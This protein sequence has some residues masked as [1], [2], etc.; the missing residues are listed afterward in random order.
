MH[1]AM[2][3]PQVVR[4]DNKLYTGGGFTNDELAAKLIVVF[5]IKEQAWS[6]YCMGPTIEFGLTQLNGKL[7]AVGG[8]E[9]GKDNDSPSNKV[10]V[11]DKKWD[12]SQIPPFMTARF[13][14]AAFSY[15]SNLIVAGGGIKMV[16][17]TIVP[18]TSVEV[19]C[20][21]TGQWH[22]AVDLPLS[23]QSPGSALSTFVSKDRAYLLYYDQ[24]MSINL[25]SLVSEP[26]STSQNQSKSEV[27]TTDPLSSWK[28]WS[29][30]L[31]CSAI[32]IVDEKLIA[33]GGRR[34]GKIK[35][36][37][38]VF[39]P[40]TNSW[41]VLENGDLPESRYHATIA[42]IDSGRIIIIGGDKRGPDGSL[43]I[44]KTCYVGSLY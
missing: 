33:I 27:Q 31:K 22:S 41:G 6:T 44:A 29:C 34:D 18:T 3:H 2:S 12:A 1:V 38:H 8:V 30:P 16:G 36:V 15:E 35:G 25:S 14:A 42:Q 7:V 39:E 28:V 21:A 26:Q 40:D 11:F 32:A 23:K 43:I 24:C 10:F 17:E 19:Y 13:Y 5:D 4:M 9:D 20:G 37:V